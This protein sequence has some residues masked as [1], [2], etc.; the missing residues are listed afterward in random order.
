MLY[1]HAAELAL[2]AFL[3][4]TGISTAILAKKGKGFGHDVQALHAAAIARGL[5]PEAELAPELMRVMQLLQSGNKDDSFRYWTDGETH[6]AEIS[7]AGRVVNELVDL[8]EDRLTPA[9]GLGYR[10]IEVP[11]GL[12]VQVVEAR[13]PASPVRVARP[14][15]S[16]QQRSVDSRAS[17]DSKQRTRHDKP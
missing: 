2:K 16:G 7:W 15:E 9:V 12:R 6:T 1:L 10:L 13:A 17:T 14:K 5:S 11:V 3:R 4:H 8:V